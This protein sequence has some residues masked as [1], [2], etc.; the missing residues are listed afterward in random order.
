[1]IEIIRRHNR[2]NGVRFSIAEFSVIALIVGFFTCYYTI[3]GRSVMA[4]I[5]WGIILNCSAV[6]AIGVYMLKS[7][8]EVKDHVPSFWKKEAR[9]ELIRQNP[10]MLRDTMTLT[11]FTIIPFLSIA[12]VLFEFVRNRPRRGRPQ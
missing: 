2:L 9:A 8:R 5:G 3:H 4:L 7:P 6:V 1:M 12:V 10:H 11:I